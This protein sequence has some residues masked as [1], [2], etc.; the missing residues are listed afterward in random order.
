MSQFL[1]STRRAAR[2]LLL[3][4]LMGGCAL[5]VAAPQ[6]GGVWQPLDPPAALLTLNGKEPPLLP[7]A[8][9]LYEQRK[10]Q[11][12]K[13]DTSFDPTETRCSPPGEPRIF[14]QDMPFDIVQTPQKLLFGF[15]WNRLVRYIELDKPM[16]V[17]SPYYFGTSVGH[18][19]GNELDV[20]V[21]G[22]ND[23]FFLD[24]SGLPHSDQLR[25][26]EKFSLSSS[27]NQL[28]LQITVND[29]KTFSG[30]WETALNFRK[31]PHTRIAE[32]ICTVRKHLVP[33]DVQFFDPT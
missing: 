23:R 7:A 4:S 28:H 27:G 8:K 6:F 26:S 12:A 31:L 29:P 3:A 2:S 33:P 13:G 21:Q 32:D 24:R 15:Q 19:V 10:A 22:F 20:D 25:L 14:T 16:D 5:A 30:P 1:F 18:F 17:I 9:V 11:L